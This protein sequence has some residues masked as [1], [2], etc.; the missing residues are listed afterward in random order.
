MKPHNKNAQV[1]INERLPTPQNNQQQQQQQQQQS[2]QQSLAQQGQQYR[3][4]IQALRPALMNPAHHLANA[5]AVIL[6]R[7]PRNGRNTRNIKR[8]GNS[9][10]SRSVGDESDVSI[11]RYSGATNYNGSPIV[12]PQIHHL[13]NQPI[14]MN[15]NDHTIAAKEKFQLESNSFPPLPGNCSFPVSFNYYNYLKSVLI[16]I[17]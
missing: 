2:Q 17:V 6:P 5:P 1:N 16:I 13:I 4:A 12:M 8:R 7:D 10:G 9:I 14:S 15:D 11:R 3:H